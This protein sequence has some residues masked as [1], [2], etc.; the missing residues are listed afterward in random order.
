VDRRVSSALLS[1]GH[2][3]KPGGLLGSSWYLD[4]EIFMA[5]SGRASNDRR[6][7]L[8]RLMILVAAVL[9]V[10]DRKSGTKPCTYLQHCASTVDP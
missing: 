7:Y 6:K 4:R 8:Y 1:K 9:A 5:V 2:V 10:G 3:L